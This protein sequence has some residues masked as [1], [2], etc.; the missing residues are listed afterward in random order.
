MTAFLFIASQSRVR[1]IRMSALIMSLSSNNT[2]ARL[3]FGDCYQAVMS[4][5][6][7]VFR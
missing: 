4:E 6:T 2:P 3:M 5:P 7:C 1:Y